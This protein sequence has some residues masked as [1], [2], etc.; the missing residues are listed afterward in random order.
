MT[1][2]QTQE[3][4]QELFGNFASEPRRHERIPS[5]AKTQK[6]ILISTTLEQILLAGIVLILVFCLVFFLGVLRGRSLSSGM[7]A[8]APQ[9]VASAMPAPRQ[10]VAPQPP[11]AV[12]DAAPTPAAAVLKKENTFVVINETS[13]KPYTIQVLTTKKK[14]Y[15]ESES[16]ILQKSGFASWTAKSGDYYV[17]CAGSYATKEEARKDLAYFASKYKGRYLRRR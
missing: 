1:E 14:A 7:V 11:V 8:R 9:A 13:A 2:P 3:N 5:I 17:V 4:Q 15:A 12:R 6:P 10:R 16:E